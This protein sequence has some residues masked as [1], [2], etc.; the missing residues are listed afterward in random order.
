MTTFRV[1][2]QRRPSLMQKKSTCSP[3]SRYSPD[4]AKHQEHME[5]APTWALWASNELMGCFASA[6]SVQNR[7]HQVFFVLPAAIISRGPGPI[8][9]VTIYVPRG[10]RPEPGLPFA[11]FPPVLG[12]SGALTIRG[13]RRSLR[14]DGSEHGANAFGLVGQIRLPSE[15]QKTPGTRREAQVY[16]VPKNLD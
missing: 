9:P 8:E 1:F 2:H 6:H 4:Q 3:T 16:R 7:K 14:F 12:T 15:S 13:S 11:H 5:S 10:P